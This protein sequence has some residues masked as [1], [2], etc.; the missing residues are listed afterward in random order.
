MIVKRIEFKLT[1]SEKQGPQSSLPLRWKHAKA[2]HPRV[3]RSRLLSTSESVTRFASLWFPGRT[4]PNEP[5]NAV[6]RRCCLVVQIQRVRYSSGS[7]AKEH[8]NE[9]S[10][11]LLSIMILI[12]QQYIGISCAWT[13][14]NDRQDWFTQPLKIMMVRVRFKYSG[15]RKQMSVVGV[16]QTL[17]PSRNL[18]ERYPT[19]HNCEFHARSSLPSSLTKTRIFHNRSVL[20]VFTKPKLARTVTKAHEELEDT[21]PC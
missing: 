2:I 3:N 12:E 10:Y 4:L 9:S 15:V 18:E 11:E 8:A 13:R 20:L 17:S 14:R 7:P 21:W 1:C 16:I 6:K 19:V 5:L